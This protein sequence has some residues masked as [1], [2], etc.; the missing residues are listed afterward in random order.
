MFNKSFIECPRYNNVKIAFLN[1]HRFG[2]CSHRKTLLQGSPINDYSNH[3]KRF[4]NGLSWFEYTR[5]KV[6][7]KQRLYNVSWSL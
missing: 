3:E 5:L 1:V 2:T 7:T 6:T 4:M